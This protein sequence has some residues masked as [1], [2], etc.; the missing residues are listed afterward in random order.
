MESLE[1]ISAAGEYSDTISKIKEQVSA[2]ASGGRNVNELAKLAQELP[3][4]D[5]DAGEREVVQE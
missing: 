1:D 4:E 3:A 5:P 2:L